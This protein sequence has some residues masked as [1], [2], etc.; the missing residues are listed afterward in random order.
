MVYVVYDKFMHV[1]DVNVMSI[2]YVQATTAG[3]LAGLVSAGHQYQIH[4]QVSN[5]RLKQYMR[6][7]VSLNH[8]DGVMYCYCLCY[9]F[10][11]H[12][13]PHAHTQRKF[14]GSFRG[15]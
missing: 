3:E 6:D 12:H 8:S 15:V 1:S 10:M 11:T 4:K 2:S 9:L 13:G 7:I 5:T 14:V